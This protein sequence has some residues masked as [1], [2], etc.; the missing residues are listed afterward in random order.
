MTRR[1]ENPA[2]EKQPMHFISVTT[3]QFAMKDPKPLRISLSAQHRIGLRD[4]VI[5][6]DKQGPSGPIVRKVVKQ[7]RKR[8]NRLEAYEV[9]ES[10]TA[11]RWLPGI[12]YAFSLNADAVPVFPGDFVRGLRKSE[13]LQRFIDGH[14][15]M[16]RLA[17]RT[18][19]IVGDYHVRE[20]FKDR[21]DARVTRPLIASLYPDVADRLS[22]IGLSKMRSEFFVLGKD[23]FD[24]FTAMPFAWS[25]DPTP[26]LL[27]AGMLSQKAMEIRTV[28]LGDWFRDDRRMRSPLGQLYQMV[29]IVCALTTDQT[30]LEQRRDLAREEQMRVYRQMRGQL[31]QAWEHLL[32]AIDE[33]ATEFQGDRS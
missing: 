19:L 32:S 11:K 9:T 1:N 23:Y 26:Q 2:P 17:S 25:A 22:R 4:A 18:R 24:T 13:S 30:R 3:A 31:R 8:F 27:L 12:R 20:L 33:N 6:H 29:R 28:D 10:E 14:K 21:F 15:E 16:L 5:V 7:Y